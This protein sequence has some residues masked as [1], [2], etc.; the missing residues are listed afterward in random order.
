MVFCRDTIKMTIIKIFNY[1]TSKCAMT[2]IDQTSVIRRGKVRALREIV[3]HWFIL[4]K[5]GQE[6]NSGCSCNRRFPRRRWDTW[7][8]CQSFSHVS[9]LVLWVPLFVPDWSFFLS[10]LI[11]HSSF[12]YLCTW[13]WKRCNRSGWRLLR[14]RLRI[15]CFSSFQCT[16]CWGFER[17]DWGGHRRCENGRKR[18]RM[19]D[20]RRTRT[21]RL[22]INS[23]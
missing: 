18:K 9:R 13:I 12:L 5:I 22:D 2:T 23:G 15:D 7:R 1:K 19:R 8:L 20:C 16:R 14:Q 4:S 3:G 17:I 6:H 11:L 21:S 10:C